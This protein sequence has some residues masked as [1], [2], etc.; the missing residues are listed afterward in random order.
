MRPKLEH[1]DF[2]ISDRGGVVENRHI[3]HVSVVDAT[4]KL[5]FAIGDPGRMTLARS[6][7][8]PIQAL[9]ILETG[10]CDQFGFDDADLA[11]ICIAQ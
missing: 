8:K 10:V 2:V 1:K 6:A 9:A 5:L 3:I 4:G 7:A 11:L